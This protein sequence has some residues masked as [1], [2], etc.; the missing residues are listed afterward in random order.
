MALL[1]GSAAIGAGTAASGITTDQ[2][3]ASRPTSGAIDIGAFQDQGYTV[4]V[5][6]GS[7]QSTMVGQAFGSP[8]VAELTE[9]FAA[10]RS[11]V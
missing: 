10:R 5:S 6:S 8:I 2:R 7:G 1:P 11:R 3:G 9:N 4:A